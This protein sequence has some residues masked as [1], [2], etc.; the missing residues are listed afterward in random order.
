M[1]L[2][3]P[4]DLVLGW[5]A[6]GS[7]R[8]PGPMLARPGALPHGPGWAFEVKWDGFRALVS[9]IDGLEVRSRR[10]W[11]MTELVPELERL[12][13]GLM[14]DGELAAWDERA[15]QIFTGSAGGC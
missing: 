13:A 15:T 11:A 6:P 3:L 8:L 7:L 9:T 5:S 14:L 1:V 12:P 10:G 2:W 4:A